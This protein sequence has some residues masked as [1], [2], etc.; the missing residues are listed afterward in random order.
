MAPWT[1]S[2]DPVGVT[3]WSGPDPE[4]PPIVQRVVYRDAAG[5]VLSPAELQEYAGHVD[6]E[7]VDAVGVPEQAQAAFRAGR[8]AGEKW[9]LR[10]A[11]GLFWKA[12]RL[13]P[14]P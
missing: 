4:V 14:A 5:R 7:L 10:V 6:F 13:A 8:E 3:P 9:K 11:T 2:A 1:A 12:H